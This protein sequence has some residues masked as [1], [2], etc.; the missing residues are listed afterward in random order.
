MNLTILMSLIGAQAILFCSL[1]GRFFF[2]EFIVRLIVYTKYR[3][4]IG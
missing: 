3:C 2:A 4:F 1:H